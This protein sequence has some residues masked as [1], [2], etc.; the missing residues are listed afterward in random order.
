MIIPS[1]YKYKWGN[2]CILALPGRTDN[3][4]YHPINNFIPAVTCHH[5]TATT[6]YATAAAALYIIFFI[7]RKRRQRIQKITPYYQIRETSK[8]LKKSTI[9]SLMTFAN[10]PEKIREKNLLDLL[11]V[12]HT[13]RNVQEK[14]YVCVHFCS[15]PSFIER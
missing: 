6:A 15:I 5:T 12:R 2:V 10:L 8:K 14:N 1:R 13:D 11:S 3:K 9:F 7:V 4:S